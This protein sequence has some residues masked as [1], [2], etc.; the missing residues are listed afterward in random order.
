MRNIILDRN[1]LLDQYITIMK[2]YMEVF[3][4]FYKLNTQLFMPYMTMFNDNIIDQQNIKPINNNNNIIY[5]FNY[6]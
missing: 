2:P 6:L 4:H 5:Y 1:G 3:L